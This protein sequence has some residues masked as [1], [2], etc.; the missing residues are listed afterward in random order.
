MTPTW[1]LTYVPCHDLQHR[2]STGGI[3]ETAKAASG[4]PARMQPVFWVFQDTSA[5]L[6]AEIMQQRRLR[7]PLLQVAGAS[8]HEGAAEWL[9]SRLQQRAYARVTV[10]PPALTFCVTCCWCCCEACCRTCRPCHA[11]NAMPRP[12]PTA[13]SRSGAPAASLLQ[14][15]STHLRAQPCGSATWLAVLCADGRSAA[16]AGGGR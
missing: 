10:P 1:K 9:K 5:G 16:A 6:I 15:L 14:C 2:G 7:R 8:A 3:R 4:S 12:P 11:L 13:D